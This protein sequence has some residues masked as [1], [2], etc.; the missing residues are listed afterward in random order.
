MFRTLA[1]DCM[2]KEYEVDF[3]LPREELNG[4]DLRFRI[5]KLYHVLQNRISV[6]S[7]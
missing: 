5:L 7:K 4:D 2:L 6:N 3:Y 1:I